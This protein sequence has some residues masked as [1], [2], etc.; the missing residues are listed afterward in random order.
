MEKLEN[1]DILEIICKDKD[2][3]LKQKLKELLV[4]ICYGKEQEELEIIT[5]D[6]TIEELNKRIEKKT[7]E[8]KA[9]MIGELLFHLKSFEELKN[10]SHIS[11]YLNREERSVKKGFDVLLFDG[12]KVWYTEVKSR[13]NAKD[14]N[15]TDSHISKIKEAIADIKGKF[16]SNNKNYWLTAKS[17]IVNVEEKDLKKQIADILTKEIDMQIEKNAIGV[18]AVFKKDI[19]NINKNKIKEVLNNE[20][21]NFKNI[22]AVCISHE[23]YKKIVEILKELE[24]GIKL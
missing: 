5:F 10:Y 8:Q 9:G 22:A 16:S 2:E 4:T 20:K 11:I 3:L 18:S 12:E 13:E 23:D 1:Q 7:D 19:D 21:D 15:I 24:N 17:N 14:E 6:E